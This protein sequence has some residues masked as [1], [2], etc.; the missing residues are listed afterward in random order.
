MK[1]FLSVGQIFTCSEFSKLCY[2]LDREPDG[3]PLI[4]ETRLHFDH[5]NKITALWTEKRDGWEKK[6][7]DVMD[8]SIHDSETIGRTEF[9]VLHTEMSGGGTGHG[10]HDIFP[11]G[12]MVVA[13]DSSGR[14]VMFYQSGCFVGMVSP[15]KINLLRGPEDVD[16]YSS[17]GKKLRKP[18][19]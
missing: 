5:S 8:L 1:N 3:R 2:R 6:H 9:H 11:D 14:R 7:E 10:P 12:H 17:D 16:P 18:I 13:E 19:W 4:N 15:E